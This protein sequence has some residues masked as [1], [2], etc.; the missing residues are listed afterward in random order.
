MIYGRKCHF[1][2]Y[3]SSWVFPFN[4]R[5]VFFF[6]RNWWDKEC[7]HAGELLT[8]PFLGSCGLSLA[9]VQWVNS[10]HCWIRLQS[11]LSLSTSLLWSSHGLPFSPL[12]SPHFTF[13][14]SSPWISL[15]Y[16]ALGKHK[17]LLHLLCLLCNVALQKAQS[18]LLYCCG[19]GWS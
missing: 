10:L 7:S 11:H 17:T 18:T 8:G 19:P 13:T 3:C 16:H 2:V 5:R 15:C 1:G 14:R 4:E 6:T 9:T 12:P